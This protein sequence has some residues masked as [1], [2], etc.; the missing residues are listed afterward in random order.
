VAEAIVHVARD[1]IAPE[2]SVPGWLGGFEPFR[3]LTPRLYRFGVTRI[4]DRF[5]ARRPLRG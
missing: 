4:V 3:V 2:C 5:G 1:G